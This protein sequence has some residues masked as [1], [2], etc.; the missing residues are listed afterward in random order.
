MKHFWFGAGLLAVLLAVSLLLGGSLD[1]VHH[2]SAKDL[3]KAAEAARQED[4]PLATALYLRAEKH[5]QRR[6]NLTAIL[7]RHD[8]IDQVDAGFAALEAYDRCKET[9]SF[10]AA[11]V[12]LARQLRSLHQP[13]SFH[14]WNLL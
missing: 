12:Q 6:R 1:G 11:C 8:L 13:H 9:A 5:W 10:A 4:W 3:E 2:S 7:A 14:W